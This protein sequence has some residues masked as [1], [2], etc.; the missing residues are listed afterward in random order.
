MV[1][2]LYKQIAS[3]WKKPKA[4]LGDTLKGRLI[5]WRREGTI[6]SVASP[7]RVDRARAL[8][9][10]AKQ[11]Y[12]LARV[13]IGKGG[14]RREYYGRRGR[15]PSKM[16][17]VHFTHGKSLGKISE[18]KAQRKYIN[19]TVLGSYLAGE[20]GKNKWFEVVLVDGSHGTTKKNPKMKWVSKNNRKSLRTR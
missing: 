15:K 11:G 8:G 2:S 6:V 9:Y 7:T 18:E 10:K 20:D 12:V 14:R 17:L 1:L 13:K 16:G 19:M 5:Q 4:N 3:V